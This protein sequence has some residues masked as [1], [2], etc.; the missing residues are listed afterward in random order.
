MGTVIPFVI[1]AEKHFE[2][3]KAS[4]QLFKIFS[5]NAAVG[6]S[7]FSVTSLPKVG[8]SSEKSDKND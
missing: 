7:Q 6:F 5:W 1:V 2:A 4:K 8:G 3:D